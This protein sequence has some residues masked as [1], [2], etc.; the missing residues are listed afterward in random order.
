[1]PS[2]RGGGI[3]ALVETALDCDKRA[4]LDWLSLNFGIE[5]GQATLEQRRAYAQNIDRARSQAA[6]LIRRR[7]ELL[8]GLW[9]E[10]DVLF[11]RY[12][13]LVGLAYQRE[14]IELLGDSIGV[15]RTFQGLTRQ[16]EALK[17][18]P[19]NKLAQMIAGSEREA[20]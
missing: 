20:S 11:V 13:D 10:A 2:E 1:M 18:A 19:G 5:R 4:A 8:V 7:D 12:H 14:D 9:A 6:A 15:W 16:Y 3:L 17:E